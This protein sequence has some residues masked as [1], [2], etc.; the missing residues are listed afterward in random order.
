PVVTQVADLGPLVGFLLSVTEGLIGLVSWV[1]F[2]LFLRK[3]AYYLDADESGDQ[4]MHLIIKGLLLL[5]GIPLGVIVGA[6][7][8]LLSCMLGFGAFL[9]RTVLL[10]IVFI[11]FRFEVLA[12]IGSVRAAIRPE[13]ST[14]TT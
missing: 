8:A 10:G 2:M 5:V 9:M 7:I 14:G 3:V 13:K 1:L 11:N 4:A 12:L 6:F